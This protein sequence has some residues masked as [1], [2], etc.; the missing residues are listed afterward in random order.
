[1]AHG[2]NLLPFVLRFSQPEDAKWINLPGWPDGLRSNRNQRSN[3]F[4]SGAAFP[5][6]ESIYS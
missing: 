6:Q 5:E 2:E 1:M 4:S 3:A